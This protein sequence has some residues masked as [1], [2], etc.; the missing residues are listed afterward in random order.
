MGNIFAGVGEVKKDDG[1][2][3]KPFLMDGDYVIEIDKFSS[4]LGTNPEKNFGEGMAILEGTVLEVTRQV[5][6]Q[7]LSAGSQFVSIYVLERD[8]KE[9]LTKDGERSMSRVKAVASAALN[10]GS[11]PLVPDEA[12]TADM[13]AVLT[14]SGGTTLAGTRVKASASTSTSQKTGK[15]FTNVRWEPIRDAE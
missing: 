6:N 5:G 3:R 8:K 4:K 15:K 12:I 1:T 2:G 11:D 14:G 7:S 10:S 9:N 13:L